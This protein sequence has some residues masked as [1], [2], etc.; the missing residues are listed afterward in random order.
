MALPP[1]PTLPVLQP[2]PH[3]LLGGEHVFLALRPAGALWQVGFAS[4][5][6]PCLRRRGMRVHR[7]QDAE[8]RAVE[9]WVHARM[10]L[11]FACL[12]VARD[13][14]VVAVQAG[15]Q[16]AHG[17]HGVVPVDVFDRTARSLLAPVGAGA[18]VVR[19]G[20][21][22]P[23]VTPVPAHVTADPLEAAL[24]RWVLPPQTRV[25]LRTT[26]GTHITAR[27]HVRQ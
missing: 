4:P 9:L 13:L 19:A 6:E 17:A 3:T 8:A 18:S 10:P 2:R 14:L 1:W 26:N 12:D 5:Y 11:L 21:T 15:P 27:A 23:A 7:G 24:A 25:E 16:G 22:L 20:L